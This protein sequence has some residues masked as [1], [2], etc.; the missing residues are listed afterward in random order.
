M[1]SAEKNF[2]EMFVAYLK[3]KQVPDEEAEKLV[4]EEFAAIMAAEQQRLLDALV[5]IYRRYYTAEEIHQLLS[6]YRTEVARKS[7]KVS[8]QIAAEAQQPVRLWNVHYES[9][10]LERL[11]IRLAEMGIELEQ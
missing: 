6:F 5:P 7:L 10:L 1:E 4:R 3:S 11:G 9:V 8:G 2:V